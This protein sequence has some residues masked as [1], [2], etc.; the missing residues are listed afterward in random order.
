MNYQIFIL[1]Q[2]RQIKCVKLCSQNGFEVHLLSIQIFVMLE[3]HWLPM[4]GGLKT[5]NLKCPGKRLLCLRMTADTT[6][7]A[8]MK[9]FPAKIGHLRRLKRRR[10]RLYTAAPS[11][12]AYSGGFLGE[13]IL[14]DEGETACASGGIALEAQDCPNA[15]NCGET[16]RFLQKGQT[17]HS[18]IRY[19][20]DYP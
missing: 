7:S 1:D 2:Q 5:E 9:I 11:L 19:A 3:R 6:V 20:F 10:V 12:V 16:F 13:D 8:A 14:L 17:W 15:P 18:E 4:L